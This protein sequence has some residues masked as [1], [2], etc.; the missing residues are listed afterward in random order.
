MPGRACFER[1]Y[2]Q[3]EVQCIA[4][5]SVDVGAV[6]QP[7]AHALVL[8]YYGRHP[9]AVEWC[10]DGDVPYVPAGE[11]RNAGPHLTGRPL[12]GR[13]WACGQ[14]LASYWRRRW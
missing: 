7:V 4:L 11:A 1:H 9:Y 10:H 13:W 14:G 8:R 3:A 12:R 6:P 5:H 2:P